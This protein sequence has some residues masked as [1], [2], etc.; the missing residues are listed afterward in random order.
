[1]LEH[2]VPIKQEA[3][4]EL[5]YGAL[6]RLAERQ[7]GFLRSDTCPPLVCLD[8][9]V[10]RYSIIHFDTPNHLNNCITSEQWEAMLESGRHLVQNYKFKS[11]TTGLEGW[12]SSR[13]GAAS[14]GPP[15]WKQVL[16]VVLGLYPIV[17][18]QG[19]L[20]EALGIMQTWPPA[21]AMLAGNLITSTILTW[22]IMP[23]ISR[24]LRFW[25]R[26][27]Y[28]VSS[29]QVNLLGALIVLSAYVLMVILFSFMPY[30]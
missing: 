5:W 30:G 19:Q 8:G 10:K 23:Q 28:A 15:R 24:L 11:F 29:V 12:F 3:S 18:L 21:S 4:F 17:I 22:V 27:A 2:V 16:A 25:L 9:V 26:P 20:F 7:A 1:V 14:L 13:D 6:I